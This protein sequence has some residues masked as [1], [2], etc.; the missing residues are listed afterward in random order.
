M[1]SSVGAATGYGLD[2]RHS[3]PGGRKKLLSTPQ[4]P[5]RIWAQFSFPPSEYRRLFPRGGDK[6]SRTDHSLP[7]SS[8]IKNCGAILPL[9]HTSK[10]I[11]H[12]DNF[13]F[14]LKKLWPFRNIN[15]LLMNSVPI[16]AQLM[17]MWF[18]LILR[19]IFFIRRHWSLNIKLFCVGYV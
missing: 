17:V 3:I 16:R 18:K 14:Y 19:S 1:D 10:L 8:E 12:K 2:S 4:R 11:K 13:T 9:H 15:F 7:P 5:D 6:A